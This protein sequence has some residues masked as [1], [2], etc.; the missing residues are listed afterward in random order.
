MRSFSPRPPR[1]FE[2]AFTSHAFIF[3]PA[4]HR[5]QDILSSSRMPA[6][7]VLFSIS[8]D[9]RRLLATS[10]RLFSFFIAGHFHRMPPKR[11]TVR[12]ETAPRFRHAFHLL[13]SSRLSYFIILFRFSFIP[14]YFI[15][16]ARAVF[17]LDGRRCRCPLSRHQ[18]RTLRLSPP[19]FADARRCRVPATRLTP[20]VSTWSGY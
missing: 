1:L 16:D 14:A 19:A 5:L 7:P 2:C 13:H 4:P 6:E 9:V 11:I 8:D 18:R 17:I 15:A 3:R 10:F 20:P 12:A